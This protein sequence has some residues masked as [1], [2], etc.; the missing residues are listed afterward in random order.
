M[1]VILTDE[2]EVSGWLDPELDGESAV[3]QLK[4]I[5]KSKVKE[6]SL[7]KKRKKRNFVTLK[8]Y[9]STFILSVQRWEILEIKVTILWTL[10]TWM[11]RVK[12]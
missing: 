10:S 3:K 1:P 4:Q 8:L 9:R 12:L 7:S 11:P 2:H 6:I 5:D